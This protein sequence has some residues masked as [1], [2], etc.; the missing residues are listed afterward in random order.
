[1]TKFSFGLKNLSVV[2]NLHNTALFQMMEGTPKEF[3]QQKEGQLFTQ[4]NLLLCLPWA[5]SQPHSST[6][7]AASQPQCCT[8]TREFTQPSADCIMANEFTREALL[9]NRSSYQD[10]VGSYRT[11]NKRK[12]GLPLPSAA[13]SHYSSPCCCCQRVMLSH[14]AAPLSS[15]HRL[16]GHSELCSTCLWDGPKL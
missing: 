15:G 14:H 9:G 6:H 16:P 5:H 2:S 10:K 1:M 12:L 13:F 7:A 4:T 3:I 11:V 8:S